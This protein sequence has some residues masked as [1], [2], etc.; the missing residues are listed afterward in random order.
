MVAHTRLVS[1]VRIHRDSLVRDFAIET[2]FY[3]L[4]LEIDGAGN[5]LPAAGASLGNLGH[6]VVDPN[7]A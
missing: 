3:K 7:R 4:T 2:C 1:S 6:D 5:A